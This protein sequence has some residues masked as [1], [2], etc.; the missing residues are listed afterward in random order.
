MPE[1]L[2]AQEAVEKIDRNQLVNLRSMPNPPP[3]ILLVFEGVCALLGAKSD[4]GTVKGLLM[5]LTKF[6]QSLI[7]Y[8]KEN[9]P[10]ARLKKLNAVLAKPEF[11]IPSIAQRASYAADMAAFCRAMKIYADTNEK[12]KPKKE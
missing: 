11:D 1:L 3:I 12:V 5:D 4:W 2:R 6:I 10:P 7:N 9:I 8:D